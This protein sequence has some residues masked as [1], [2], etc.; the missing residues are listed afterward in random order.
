MGVQGLLWKCSMEASTEPTL[1]E[2]KECCKDLLSFQFRF[3]PISNQSPKYNFMVRCSTRGKVKSIKLCHIAAL[4]CY[5]KCASNEVSSVNLVY[6]CSCVMKRKPCLGSVK[7]T[8]YAWI[9]LER[10]NAAAW[11]IDKHPHWRRRDLEFHTA[12]LSYF[13][14]KT[15]MQ[16]DQNCD[17]SSIRWSLRLR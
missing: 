1:L 4:H 13:S 8:L 5:L 7:K 11:F 6:R 16:N 17:L 10:L 3:H 12:P 15:S 14:C 2:K 9:Q